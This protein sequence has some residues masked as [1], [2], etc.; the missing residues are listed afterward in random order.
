[1]SEDA[2]STGTHSYAELGEVIEV[3]RR[4]YCLTKGTET[5]EGA[6]VSNLQMMASL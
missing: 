5:E 4:G 6:E 3:L 1:M 2:V